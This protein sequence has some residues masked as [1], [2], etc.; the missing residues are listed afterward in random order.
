M[1]LSN[2]IYEEILDWEKERDECLKYMKAYPGG[3]YKKREGTEIF[4]LTAKWE[5]RRGF[6][7]LIIEYKLILREGP[8]KNLSFPILPNL[9]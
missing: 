1:L 2:E 7:K 8:K 5:D 3:T 9:L 4:I 6:T